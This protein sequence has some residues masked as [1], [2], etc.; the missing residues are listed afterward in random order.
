MTPHDRE[1]ERMT[2]RGQQLALLAW[3]LLLAAVPVMLLVMGS[4]S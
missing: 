1:E 3:A 2:E 4:S